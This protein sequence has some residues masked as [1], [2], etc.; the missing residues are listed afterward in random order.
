MSLLGSDVLVSG[1]L[2][3]ALPGG[4]PREGVG[5]RWVVMKKKSIDVFAT[6][7]AIT[8]AD[9]LA[10]FKL[11][12]ITDLSFGTKDGTRGNQHNFHWFGFCTVSGQVNFIAS[13]TEER[14]RWLAEIRTWVPIRKMEVDKKMLAAKAE[15]QATRE[16]H[17]MQQQWAIS[18]VASAEQRIV[19]CHTLL[20]YTRELS[21]AV[22]EV[23]RVLE[24]SFV[25]RMA[26][27]Q[28]L[29]T[30]IDVLVDKA[31]SA[32]ASTSN[33]EIKAEIAQQVRCAVN[34]AL[35][36]L[37]QGRTAVHDPEALRIFEG[38]SQAMKA[39]LIQFVEY[40]HQLAMCHDLDKQLSDLKQVVSDL[41]LGMLDDEVALHEQPQTLTP[42]EQRR[43]FASVRKSQTLLVQAAI[44]RDPEADPSPTSTSPPPPLLLPSSSSSSS[45]SPVSSPSSPPPSP[46]PPPPSSASTRPPSVV[47]KHTRSES[48][49]SI[50][51]PT[52]PDRPPSTR[53]GVPA[54]KSTSPRSTPTQPAT[55]P[56][57]PQ[58]TQPQAT[59]PRSVLTSSSPLLSTSPPATSSQL[60]QQPKSPTHRVAP[61]SGPTEVQPIALV[62]DEP[63]PRFVTRVARQ[64]RLAQ[65]QRVSIYAAKALR[66][67]ETL[68]DRSKCRIQEEH[69]GKEKRKEIFERTT[70]MINQGS[71]LVLKMQEVVEKQK[72]GAVGKEE[73]DLQ[74]ESL[75]F[76]QGVT[77]LEDA[78]CSDSVIQTKTS[79]RMA[80]RVNAS[81]LKSV[82]LS[83]DEGSSAQSS[84]QQSKPPLVPRQ[85]LATVSSTSP[86]GSTLARS[87]SFASTT[88]SSSS[89]SD[90]GSVRKQLEQT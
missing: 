4:F 61:V 72:A 80:T 82:S 28:L 6:N 67:V 57:H 73:T 45:P 62:S 66:D 39:S 55:Q 79:R 89:S 8:S 78:V 19:V 69:T 86:S 37:Q 76:D 20:D 83:F 77:A 5:R 44:S 2:I 68:L 21:K 35:N 34:L 13:T 9:R 40:L 65:Q 12:A 17:V 33:K 36:F 85:R 11:Y 31:N 41:V 30:S 24:I 53:L 71:R 81:E 48:Q 26:V 87:I 51:P 25:E 84:S 16:F 1:W 75:V 3:D 38:E 70:K 42:A 14:D 60:Q 74:L 64:P 47:P 29:A 52:R 27:S 49:P 15:G 46:S 18:Q 43:V 50:T 10:S 7:T 88:Y 59:S 90:R 32:I 54:D 22:K 23:L 63:A 58:A 56:T